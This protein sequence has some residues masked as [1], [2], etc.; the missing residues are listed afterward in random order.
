MRQNK[1]DDYKTKDFVKKRKD[2]NMKDLMKRVFKLSVLPILC[3]IALTGCLELDYEILTDT[4]TPT[5]AG[6]VTTSPTLTPTT[7]AKDNAGNLMQSSIAVDKSTGNM[8]ITR[9]S[10]DGI[11]MGAEDSWTI[12]V[13]LCGSDLETGDGM[14][15]DDLIEMTEATESENV[16][17]IVQTGG[18]NEWWNDVV[19][20]DCMQRFIVEDGNITELWKQKGKMTSSQTLAD[21]LKWGVETYPAEHM[22]VIFWDHGSGSINGVCF[23]ETDDYSSLLLRDLDAAFLSVFE[24]MTDKFELIG[25]DACLMGTLETANIFASYARYMVASEETE[26]GS[27]WDYTEIG[28]YLA[29]NPDANGLE[30]GKVICDT[31][32]ESCKETG[33]EDTVTLSVLDLDA[34][35]S[36]IM[37]F[38]NF[39]KDIYEAGENEAK[40]AN[41][42]RAISEAENFGGNN[43]NEGYTNMVDLGGL[44]KACSTYSDNVSSLLDSMKYMVLYVKNGADHANASGVSLYYPLSVQ[45]SSEL[46][47]FGDIC[48]S[49]FYLSFVDR[50]DHGSLYYEGN[51]E[52]SDDHW[53]DDDG[54]WFFGDSDDYTYNDDC[55]CY[56][57]GGVFS[58]YWDDL[59]Q[60]VA[61]G[62]SSRITFEV[63]PY[64]ND[65]GIYSFKL[66]ENGINNAA[67]VYGYVY[68]NV[69]DDEY[70]LFG[71]TLDV[72]GDWN[73]GYFEDGFTGYWLSLPDGQNLSLYIADYGDGY[74]VYTSPITLNGEDTNLR[75]RQSL[76]DDSITIEGIWDGISDYGA[77]DRKNSQ[78][79]VGDEIIPLY[80]SYSTEDEDYEGIWEGETYVVDKNMEII[81]ALLPAADYL[82]AFCIDDIYGDYYMTDFVYFGVDENGELWY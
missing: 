62:T 70:V 39:A 43:K 65:D 73:T 23:D 18:A 37:E 7:A 40:L 47:I 52:Y 54:L 60:Y 12:F 27:G 8:E 66:D 55:G 48:P 14:A 19:Q 59:D 80:Y 15:T 74:V 20:A 56:E 2:K 1:P 50:L 71:E 81:Y 78:L 21:F 25:F 46:K 4:P 17:F 82:Y 22:G 30:L 53:Y 75:I 35:N 34:V 38:N 68:C 51:E 76:V 16:K 79:K 26:P 33:E 10:N 42:V 9:P 41:M 24:I 13:Y 31:F 77:A 29:K 36:V 28:N 32:Y 44:A 5:I 3:A 61:T 67:A 58:D 63:A 6:E 64:V 49:P 57:Y 69:D 72:Y 11:P 45:G